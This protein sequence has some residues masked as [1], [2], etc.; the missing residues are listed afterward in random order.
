MHVHVHVHVHAGPEDRTAEFEVHQGAGPAG[1]HFSSASCTRARVH[2]GHVQKLAKL[3]DTGGCLH[4]IFNLKL[5]LER[6][7]PFIEDLVEEKWRPDRLRCLNR[8]FEPSSDQANL[9]FYMS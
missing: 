7:S 8:G 2:M 9:N 4:W 5:K 3:V 6:K 1:R